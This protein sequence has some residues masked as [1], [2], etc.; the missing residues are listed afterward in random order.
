MTTF[1]FKLRSVSLLAGIGYS[2]FPALYALAIYVNKKCNLQRP[3][4]SKGCAREISR[5]SFCLSVQQL[6]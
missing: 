2:N 3:Q 6:I 1:H 5:A 4:N